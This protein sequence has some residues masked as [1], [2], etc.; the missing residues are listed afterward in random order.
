METLLF[1][2]I[3]EI[4]RE[5]EL[6]ERKLKVKITI[7][8]KKVMFE[9]DSLDEYEASLVF[10]AMQFG[11]SAEDALLLKDEE[12]T[13]KKVNIKNFTRRRNLADVRAR[14]IGK[15]GRTKRTI[16]NIASCRLVIKGNEVGIIGSA[17][18][19]DHAITALTNLIRGS[20]QSNVYNF[21]E[22]MNTNKK[23]LD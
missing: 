23:M 2:S 15:Y 21:L 18:E 9:G 5:K 22:R 8:G 3:G 14:V 1:P 11:F 13:F 4:K 7:Q 6:L 19:I 17:E 16:Q 10:E 20:K 12:V